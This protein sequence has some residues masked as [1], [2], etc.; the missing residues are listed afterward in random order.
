MLV[1]GN[2]FDTSSFT[3]GRILISKTTGQPSSYDIYTGTHSTKIDLKAII[4]KD[5]TKAF[6]VFANPSF[7]TL[8]STIIYDLNPKMTSTKTLPKLS[9]LS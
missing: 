4:A 8:I 5:R 6:A 9:G 3:L 2:S 7:E 1:H